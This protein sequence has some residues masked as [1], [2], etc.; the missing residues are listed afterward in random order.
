M[1]KLLS[2]VLF[3][4]VTANI[5][6]AELGAGSGSGY[7]VAID[8][9]ISVETSTHTARSDVPNDLADAI[10]NIQT[11]L[12]TN[13]SGIAAS[14]K[15][16]M[17]LRACSRA[18]LNTQQSDITHQVYTKILFD[19]ESY[20]I[21]SDFDVTESTY[22]V[23]ITGYY[24]INATMM[25]G[26][27]PQADTRYIMLV[28]KNG[29]SVLSSSKHASINVFLTTSISD[30]LHFTA[31]DGVWIVAYNAHAADDTVD[32]IDGSQYT[33]FSIRFITQ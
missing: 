28:Y 20:D 32:I 22:T 5:F 29:S 18:Y 24:Q 14:V 1:R 12:G 17:E 4:F 8:T 30:T 11:E 3:L 10:I 13:P 7:P 6:G 33:W 15:E 25:W 9:D 27:T 31:G 26:A 23:P 21:G 19:A 16:R 2:A